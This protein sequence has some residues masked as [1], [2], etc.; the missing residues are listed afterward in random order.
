MGKKTTSKSVL[1]NSTINL[2]IVDCIQ[3]MQS[4]KLF[5]KEILTEDHEYSLLKDSKSN[6]HK[7]SQ[8]A[9]D[10]L[11]RYF[12]KLSFSHAQEKFEKIGK[13][14]N[15][16]DLLSEANIGILKAIEKFKLEKWGTEHENGIKLRFSSYAKWWI[17]S[18]LNDY[19]LKNSSSIKFC[20]T[21]EDEKIFY[22]IA[23]ILIKLKI[24]KSCC[25]L[26]KEE[27]LKVALKLNVSEKNVKK[28]I[29]SMNVSNS[30]EDLDTYFYNQSI[31]ES[32]KN[33]HSIDT[34]IDKNIL[35]SKKELGIYNEYI[36]GHGLEKLAEK[37]ESN[38]ETIRQILISSTK[39][40]NTE[41]KFI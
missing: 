34:N 3:K 19:C 36:A 38:K 29:N 35:L 7:T 39:K 41:K 11:F 26:N 24:D 32:L 23:K 13:R 15:F 18:S 20:T 12:S 27:I 33:Q 37:F 4:L 10:K 5:K 8:K 30:T 16:E 31:V 28:Y 6:D 2:E 9:I 40:L 14:I 22:N 17:T 21:K 1:N 25:D